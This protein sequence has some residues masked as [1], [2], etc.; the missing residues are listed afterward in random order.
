LGTRPI[1]TYIGSDLGESIYF[2]RFKLTEQLRFFD[3]LHLVNQYNLYVQDEWK[4]R[5]NLTFNYGVCW[6]SIPRRIPQTE[7]PCRQHA[8]FDRTIFVKADSWYKR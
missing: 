3:E 8:Y 1:E 6:K 5:N 7:N 4:A 2:T